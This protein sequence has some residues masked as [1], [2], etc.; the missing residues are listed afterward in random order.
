MPFTTYIRSYIR[1]YMYIC[2]RNM[3]YIR[4]IYVLFY[5]VYRK[6]QMQMKRL[7]GVIEKNR[8]YWYAKQMK[9]LNIWYMSRRSICF[10]QNLSDALA[11]VICTYFVFD[12]V[13]PRNVYRL[14]IFLQHTMMSIRDV[15]KMPTS[16]MILL[17]SLSNEI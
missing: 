17:S 16:V 12:L 14:L 13:Y 9:V 8:L 3:K 10:P 6:L 7:K 1:T 15:E 5:F 4:N 11:D 2:I